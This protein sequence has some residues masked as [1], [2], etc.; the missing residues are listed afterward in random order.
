MSRS[1]MKIIN[2]QTKERAL[3]CLEEALREGPRYVGKPTFNQWVTIAESVWG[4]P[5]KTYF[6][7]LGTALLAKA[8]WEDADPLSIKAIS[9]KTDT[10]SSRSLCH[11]VLV[12]FA[13]QNQVDLRSASREPLNNQPFFRYNHVLEVERVRFPEAF[14]EL[15][16][17]LSNARELSPSEA[18]VALAAFLRVGKDHHRPLEESALSEVGVEPEVVAQ[19]I[20]EL[21]H[22]H[23]EGGKAAQA[24]AAAGVEVVY[25]YSGVRTH[26]RVNDPGR[27]Y[28]GD[29]AVFAS[30]PEEELLLA[31]EARGKG[32]SASDKL[33]F[34]R[35]VAESGASK[36]LMLELVSEEEG[37]SFDVEAMRRH[38]VLLLHVRGARTFVRY[39]LAAS[40]MALQKAARKLIER[41]LYHMQVLGAGDD[42]KAK[43]MRAVGVSE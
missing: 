3:R 36:G 33:I 9:G 21:L 5:A 43:I 30:G 27:H 23:P 29:V 32:V 35:Q 20:H 19:A 16:E 42:A 10:Y 15:Q 2:H 41:L 25:P 8:L 37:M 1:E 24:V 18:K 17:A 14:S 34:A 28:P 11:N 12:P 38:K 13:E 4:A 40:P 7:F 22:A 26:L 31:T 6:P 39:A